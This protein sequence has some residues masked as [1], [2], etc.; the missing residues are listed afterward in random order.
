[1][2]AEPTQKLN[3]RFQINPQDY[4]KVVFNSWKTLCSNMISTTSNPSY[5][6]LLGLFTVHTNV[7]TNAYLSLQL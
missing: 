7:S 4:L 6:E 1:M 5:L 2:H 3:Q